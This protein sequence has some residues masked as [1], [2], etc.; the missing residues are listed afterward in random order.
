[1]TD[2]VRHGRGR[3][4]YGARSRMS[5]IH[6]AV[7][8]HGMHAEAFSARCWWWGGRGADCV[9]GR[10]VSVGMND[11]NLKVREKAGKRLDPKEAIGGANHLSCT[12]AT[13]ISYAQHLT[14]CH[15][16]W[17]LTCHKVQCT[18]GTAHGGDKGQARDVN[19]RPA[20]RCGLRSPSQRCRCPR[21]APC[22]PYSDSSCNRYR[23][24]SAV[25]SAA[26]CY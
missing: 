19:I 24:R 14:P 4:P 6:L 3:V 15:T 7:S 1:M 26:L 16:I 9:C 5:A 22:I 10:G 25:L 17:Q 18:L 21:H 2:A 11:A 13:D 20:A 8:T 12:S 23:S